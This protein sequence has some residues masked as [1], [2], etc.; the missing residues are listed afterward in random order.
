[1]NDILSALLSALTAI[2]ADG[3]EESVRSLL[4]DPDAAPCA[5]SSKPRNAV[6]YA[7][8][9]VQRSGSTHLTSL[10]QN[11]DVAGKPA[12]F[13]NT[14]YRSLP[15]E[16]EQVFE[17]T[18]AHSI[19]SAAEKYACRSVAD[20]LNMVAELTRSENGVFG[21]KMDLCHMS[22]LLRRGLFWSPEWNWKY[23]YLTRRDLLMQAIS[24][25]T[26][27]QTGLWSS[28]SVGESNAGFDEQA[29]AEHMLYLGSLMARWEC[30]F[31]VL[32]I[33]PLRIAYEEI[34][35]A[36]ED[37][38]VRCL[39]HIGV[40]YTSQPL[41]LESAYRRQRSSRADTW[42][43]EIR[44]RARGVPVSLSGDPAGHSISH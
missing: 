9:Y 16:R 21:L 2:G 34:E 5:P 14:G 18:G 40:E 36:P 19:A 22:I 35:S 29:I 10:L 4:P 41:P 8:C 31:A 37:T 25:Y 42:A 23:I 7:I 13:F 17:R 24:F 3:T 27:S 6:N 12:D 32:G 11:T 28:L 20:Y 15:L 39:R 30:I 43:E 44:A 38:L 33:Q 26:A 1:V